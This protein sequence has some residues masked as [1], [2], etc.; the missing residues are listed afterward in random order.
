MSH[1]QH[2]YHKESSGQSGPQ[3]SGQGQH[4]ENISIFSVFF[5]IFLS[6]LWCL[7]T[8]PDGG[9]FWFALGTLILGSIWGVVFHV[10]PSK[11]N[12]AQRTSGTDL[13]QL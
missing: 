13:T 3:F 5:V 1:Y 6:G 10:L 11:T 7:N 9:S 12:T 8:F 4:L 2:D